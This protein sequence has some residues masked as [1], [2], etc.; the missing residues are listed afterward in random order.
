MLPDGGDLDTAIATVERWWR[1]ERRAFQIACALGYGT[2]LSLDTLREL[3]LVLRWI[4][5]R[6]M[7]RKFGVFLRE[8]GEEAI[9]IAAE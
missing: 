2:R 6:R 4:R 3:R 8:L 9:A 5:F 1:D 7:E